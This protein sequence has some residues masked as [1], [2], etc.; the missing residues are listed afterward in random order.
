MAHS[1]NENPFI[2]L[3]H[4]KLF[5]ECVFYSY[6]DLLLSIAEKKDEI[7]F[8]PLSF[9]LKLIDLSYC[10]CVVKSNADKIFGAIVA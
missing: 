9:S 4:P 8:V 3:K 2:V 10:L 6:K 7:L 5:S 1:V